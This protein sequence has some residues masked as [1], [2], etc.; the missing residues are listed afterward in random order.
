MRWPLRR[1]LTLPLLAV[2]VASLAAVGAI[3]AHFAARQTRQ[4]IQRQVDGVTTVLATSNFPLTSSV[5]EQMR[6]LSGAE[7]VVTT[8]DGATKSASLARP[9][10]DLPSAAPVEARE[11]P[12]G[13]KLR[14]GETTYLHRITPLPLYGGGESQMLHVLFPEAEYRSAWQ[15]AFLPPLVIG[16][17]TLLAVAAVSH[18]AARRLTIAAQR[19]AGEMLRIASGDFNA[20]PLPKTDDEIRD[21]FQSVN[22]TAEKLAEYDG[23]VRRAEQMRTVALLGAG[24]AHEMRNASTG[25]RVA[26]DLHREQCASDSESLDVAK[27]QLNLMES[28]LQRF[29]RVGK[30]DTA[31]QTREFDLAALVDDLLSLVRPVARHAGV[32]LR[33]APPGDFP[34]VAGDE[35]A[36]GQAIM[37]LLLNAIE[38]SQQPGGAP[39]RVVNTEIHARRPECAEV[40]VSD[41]GPGPAQSVAATL[42]NPFVTS[43]PEGV[44]LGLAVVKRVVEEHRGAVDWLRADGMTTFR[45]EIPLAAK[46]V[47]CV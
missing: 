26:L 46:G 15:A 18:V 25:C 24:L 32:A 1:Q 13:S 31:L 12:L 8:I 41:S 11:L 47:R 39:A 35:E 22:V 2:A 6:E 23:Q 27:R 30:T 10:R 34:P 3:N 4:R 17:I 40:V 7:F 43:K 16:V 44:G 29:L 21:L 37:N 33:W 14:M 42:F 20:A 45:V 9:P 5:L 36:I 38:A 28:Q 19:L